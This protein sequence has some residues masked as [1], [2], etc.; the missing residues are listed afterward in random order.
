M[1]PFAGV[2]GGWGRHRLPTGS[3]HLQAWLPCPTETSQASAHRIPEWLGWKR[4]PAAGP[5]G[6]P[7]PP[8]TG[9]IHRSRAQ[10]RSLDTHEGHSKDKTRIKGKGG[11]ESSTSLRQQQQHHRVGVTSSP[12]PTPQALAGLG[13]CWGTDTPTWLHRQTDTQTRADCCGGAATDGC[14]GALGSSELMQGVPGAGRGH[15]GQ[16]RA[17][18]LPGP[19]TAPAGS[20]CS[21]LCIR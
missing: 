8:G 17:R 10:R 6:H 12:Q 18:T 2:R 19:G 3:P 11:A 16:R 15:W 20:L 5:Q 13:T 1:S 14:D 7:A 4:P 9:S 21:G